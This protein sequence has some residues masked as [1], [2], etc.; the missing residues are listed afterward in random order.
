MVYGVS[1]DGENSLLVLLG[2][3]EDI[4]KKTGSA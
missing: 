4:E 3:V 2:S 1:E